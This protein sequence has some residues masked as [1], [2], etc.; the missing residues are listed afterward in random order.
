MNT[1]IEN[2]IKDGMTGTKTAGSLLGGANKG[3]PSIAVVWGTMKYTIA[4][5]HGVTLDKQACINTCEG[6]VNCLSACKYGCSS[7]TSGVGNLFGPFL[8][9]DTLGINTTINALLTYRIG[10]LYDNLYGPEKLGTATS[11]FGTE[12]YKPILGVPSLKEFQ[13]FW[14]MW[15]G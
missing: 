12:V 1:K 14:R 4:Q 15:K 3:T 11:G 2:I 8:E 7:L 5:Y 10:K 9:L 13:D 6:I